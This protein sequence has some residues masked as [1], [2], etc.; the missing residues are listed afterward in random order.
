MPVAVCAGLAGLSLLATRG[1][2]AGAQA[3]IGTSVLGGM[4]TATFLAIF[5]IP[6]FYV[7]VVQV[8]WGLWLL[9]LGGILLLSSFVLGGAL[10]LMLALAAAVLGSLDRPRAVRPGPSRAEET[11]ASPWVTLGDWR[12]GGKS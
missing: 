4:I 8:F 12:I 3:A 1:A 9:P 6:L 11:A 10:S 2:G 5:F 7:L